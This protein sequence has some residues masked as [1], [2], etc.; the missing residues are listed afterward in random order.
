MTI[1][2]ARTMVLIIVTLPQI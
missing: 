1:K 2:Y